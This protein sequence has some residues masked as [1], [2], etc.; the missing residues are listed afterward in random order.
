MKSPRL[1]YT[2]QSVYLKNHST[3]KALL[4]VTN[5]W[6]QNIENG[7]ITGVCFFEISKCFN[8]IDHDTLLFKYENMVSVVMS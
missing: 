7:L 6:Y 2:N 5:D 4:K 1:Y 3:Q 8:A